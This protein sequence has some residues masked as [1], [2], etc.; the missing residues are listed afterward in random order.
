MGF[1]QGNN[2][3]IFPAWLN[4]IQLYTTKPSKDFQSSKES[5]LVIFSSIRNSANF[6]SEFNKYINQC[7]IESPPIKNF[8]D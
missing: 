7:S 1:I 5:G 8:N 2:K 6:F 3:S 4:E